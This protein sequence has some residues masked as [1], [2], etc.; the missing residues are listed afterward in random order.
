MELVYIIG[1]SASGKTKEVKNIV[2]EL[3]SE[4][5][6]SYLFIGPTG[7]YTKNIREELLEELG[8]L[9]SS[10]FLPIDHFAVEVMKRFRPDM[11]H[12]DNHV[13][14]LFVSEILEELGRKEL[15]GSPIFIEYIVDMI[16]DVKENGGFGELFSQ[17][18]ELLPF[19]RAIYEKYA[20]RMGKDLYDTFDAYLMAPEFID[21]LSF[22]EFGKVLVLDGFHDFTPALRTFL[23][24]IALSFNK[25]YIT[26]NEDEKRKDL[27]SETKSIFL[28]AEEL[29]RK[30][31]DLSGDFI[32]ES[33]QYLEHSHF[34]E[35]LSSFHKN[36]FSNLKT[37][38]RNEGV[39]VVSAADVFSEV[40]FIAKEVKS[41]LEKGYEPG[42]ISIVA[43]DFNEYE[44]LLSKKFEE[45]K[46]PF[47][48]EG[49]TPLQDS[50]AIKL[51]LLPLETAVSGYRPEK[52]M[53]MIDF[54]YGGQFL[55]TR[56]FESVMV[57]SYLYYDFKRESYTRRFE[58]W[59]SRLKSYKEYLLKKITSIEKFTDEEFQEG[60]KEPYQ[61]IVDKIDTE[62]IPAVKKVF[63]VLE[64]LKSARKRDCRLFGGYFK[65]WREMLKLEESYEKAGNQKELRA[66]D[67]F[68]NRVLPDLEKLLAY[69]GKRRLSPSEYHKY[70][71]I[72]LRNES[73]KEWVNFS[74]RVEI[75][76]L[77]S[78]RFAK[79]AV[80]FFAG[81]RDGSYPSVKLNPLYSFSQYS[82]N[83][84]K[85][86]LL[87]REKQQRLNFYLAVSRAEDL[88]Y[89]TYPESTVEGEPILPSPYLKE[90]LLSAHVSSYSYGRSSGRK[91]GVIPT[92]D[93]AMSLEEL[94]I[95]VAR[96][97]RTPLWM[98]VKSKAEKLS[99]AFDFESFFQDLSLFHRHFDW[100]IKDTS[101]IEKRISR[102]FSYS[103]LS[104][105]QNCPFKF[106]LSYLLKLPMGTETLFELS[107]LE[108]GNVY[109][110][111]L[112]EYFK[113]KER[114]LEKLISNQLKV[115]LDTDREIIFKF[116]LQRLKEV[117]EKYLYEKEAKRPQK[118][119]RDYIPAFFEIS[120]GE[121]KNPIEIVEGIFLK[122]KIDRIDVDE[123]SR[124]MYIIDYKRGEGSGEK[125]QL[126][127]YSIA[128]EKL[129]E[130]EGY[131]VEGGTFR[132]LLGT[133]ASKD[134]FVILNEE[135][136]ADEKIWKFLRNSFNREY[137]ET[138]VKEIT[139]GI[140][141]GIFKPKI[142]EE[143]SYCFQCDYSK[144]ARICPVLLWRKSME[145]N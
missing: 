122:G 55:D 93:K 46:V 9:V 129:F 132:P 97:F 118:M 33:R 49:D 57:N 18:D 85:D 26:V 144:N 66:L 62:I 22:N 5:P 63:Q 114:D 25:V 19:L 90:V 121:K 87:T 35:K 69:I 61:K 36:F 14:R 12:I 71:S 21:E 16:H 119:K 7:T 45:Y 4:D 28:F 50:Y 120:F 23:S 41:L 2:K 44:K 51:L 105:Y 107:E 101:L 72:R 96:Y 140:F 37:D 75:Q 115:V 68:F 99:L 110:A 79:K 84:P 136:G 52:L 67:T 131:N 94:K 27:F 116:E 127:L 74:D 82:E 29:L 95:A 8:T 59:L 123:E 124:T 13:A 42:E 83:R 138:K 73:F 30:G 142:L 58:R 39:K 40:E 112:S 78:A 64:P 80:K 102:V 141:S 43:E 20:E 70:L 89:F 11:L 53:A 104:T 143:R 126:I 38:R 145:E 65:A 1:P 34:P 77:L 91:E 106:F 125:D 3:H 109:H 24:T 128:A 88:L 56:L 17:D 139:E 48:S 47:R 111:V 86:L 81:F 92:L 32:S 76:P 108:E 103:R 100:Q 15:S 133:K 137:I 113:G 6:F 54:G 10:R 130:N 135:D 134:S 117:L 60:Q 31:Q 98:E